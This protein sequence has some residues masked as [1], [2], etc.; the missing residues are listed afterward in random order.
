MQMGLGCLQFQALMGV[1]ERILC[2]KG[3]SY[4]DYCFAPRTGYWDLKRNGRMV[5]PS[6]YLL[7][8][9]GDKCQWTMPGSD[10]LQDMSQGVGS[11]LRLHWS[12]MSPLA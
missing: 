2:S 7:C 10:G 3:G 1:L 6:I 12:G 9:I 5:H 4:P 11:G 8:V